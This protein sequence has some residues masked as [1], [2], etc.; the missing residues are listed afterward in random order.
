[1]HALTTDL[2][3]NRLF[4]RVLRF[5]LPTS[6]CLDDQTETTSAAGKFAKAEA[7]A[8][9][10]AK[11]EPNFAYFDVFIRLGLRRSRAT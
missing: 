6:G 10:R 3:C 11:K 5:P 2:I 1:M 7:S 8:Q 4:S 9:P